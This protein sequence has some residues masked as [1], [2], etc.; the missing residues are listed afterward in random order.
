MWTFTLIVLVIAVLV[1]GAV[2]LQLIPV[3][4]EEAKR[5]E[6]QHEQLAQPGMPSPETTPET[7]RLELYRLTPG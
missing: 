1:L 2:A 5:A 6:K 4:R 7:R 3:G